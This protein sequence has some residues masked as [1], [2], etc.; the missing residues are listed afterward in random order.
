MLGSKS[1]SAGGVV[2]SKLIVKLVTSVISWKPSISPNVL[3]PIKSSAFKLCL[4]V[5]VTV[6]LLLAVTIF[7]IGN[8][9]AKLTRNTVQ[10]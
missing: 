2:V 4:F 7:E 8:S 10:S 1:T 6:T 3:N 9:F 5:N